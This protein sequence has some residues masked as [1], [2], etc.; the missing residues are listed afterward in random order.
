M[1]AA[2]HK[3]ITQ[4]LYPSLHLACHVLEATHAASPH[5]PV[6]ATN[7]RMVTIQSEY[8]YSTAL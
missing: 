7:S 2:R 8:S 4:Q 3:L 6:M 5:H 1:E